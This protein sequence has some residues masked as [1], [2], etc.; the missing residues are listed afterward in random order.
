[1]GRQPIRNHRHRIV[2]YRREHE[3]DT[4][5]GSRRRPS[6]AYTVRRARI[7]RARP[8]LAE[9]VDSQCFSRFVIS[10]S[11]DGVGW[12]VLVPTIGVI[13]SIMSSFGQQKMEGIDPHDDSGGV[14]GCIGEEPARALVCRDQR[15]DGFTRQRSRSGCVT[16]VR[17]CSGDGDRGSGR[18][19]DSK[20]P[21]VPRYAPLTMRVIPVMSTRTVSLGVAMLSFSGDAVAATAALL[22]FGLRYLY[23]RGYLFCL[24]EATRWCQATSPRKPTTSSDQ[25]HR[26]PCARPTANGRR[27]RPVSKALKSVGGEPARRTPPPLRHQR[28]CHGRPRRCREDRRSYQG[29][30]DVV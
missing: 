13:A 21:S 15:G 26:R 16:E 28:R 9:G 8:T 25:A 30:S 18:G 24:K 27:G 7:E 19:V 5:K 10:D 22:A 29:G 14:H 20:R 12:V 23:P 6:S 17:P 3:P 4:G 2:Q 1:M 11:R